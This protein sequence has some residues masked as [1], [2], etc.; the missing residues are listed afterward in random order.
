MQLLEAGALKS[1][2][3]AGSPAV[4][5]T[6]GVTLCKLWESRASRLLH[7]VGDGIYLTG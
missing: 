1:E 2:Y 7:W 4:P 5:L 3:W 6:D